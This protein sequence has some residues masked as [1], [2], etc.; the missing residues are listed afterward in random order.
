MRPDEQTFAHI[1]K[2]KFNFELANLSL[3]SQLLAGCSQ[4]C[5]FRQNI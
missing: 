4:F 2:R 3:P 5:D 1:I